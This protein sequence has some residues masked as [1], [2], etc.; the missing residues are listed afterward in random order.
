[1][2][3]L[4]EPAQRYTAFSANAMLGGHGWADD[5]GA[6]TGIAT[7]VDIGANCL[8]VACGMAQDVKDHR[9]GFMQ[10][11][12]AAESVTGFDCIQR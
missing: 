7:A 12:G 10:V 11:A 9:H 4:R 5:P 1:M 8:C 6:A 3:Y 2:G